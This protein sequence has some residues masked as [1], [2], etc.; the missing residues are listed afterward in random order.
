MINGQLWQLD[1]MPGYQIVRG[2]STIGGFVGFDYQESSLQPEDPTNPLRGTATG[3]KVEGHYY[4]DDATQPLDVSLV[5]E[6][7]TAFGTYYAE[8]RLGARVWDK[9]FIGPAASVDGD[10]GYDAQRL[11][12]YA[13]YTFELSK[14]VPVELSAAGGHQFVPGA[15][16]SGFGGGEGPFGTLDISTNF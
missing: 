9:L 14:G 10:S 5:G 1:V 4:F 3:V 13:K 12:G 15:D 6:Y 8:L 7:S 2:A 16:P 11:G